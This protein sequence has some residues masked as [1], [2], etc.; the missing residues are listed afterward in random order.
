MPNNPY[1]VLGVSPD[2]SEEEIT[3][4]YR[5]LAKKYHPD[6]NPGDKAAE[7]KMREINEA[8]SSIKNGTASTQNSSAS[9]GSGQGYGGGYQYG[10]FGYGPFGGYYSYGGQQQQRQSSPFDPVK[11]YIRAGYYNEALNVLTNIK[12]RSAEWYYYSS[13]ANYG[14]GNKITA[15][16]HAKEA[17]RLDPNNPVYAQNLSNIQS[18]GKAYHKESAEFGFP[19]A[20]M[21]KICFGL[22][23]ARFFCPFCC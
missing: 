20:N 14:L 2:A 10:P 23:L 1:T 5:K 18:G 8:Y 6:L 4:A 15:L 21:N 16:E 11:T 12:E 19:V 13:V 17:A 22:C 3:K 7:E 9:G